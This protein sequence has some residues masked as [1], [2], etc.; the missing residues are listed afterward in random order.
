MNRKIALRSYLLLP[1]LAVAIFI[2]APVLAD[3]PP[4]AAPPAAPASPA[5]LL[6]TRAGLHEGYARL[7]FAAPPGSDVPNPA[8]ATLEGTQLRVQLAAP[9]GGSLAQVSRVL[10]S[11]I[12]GLSLSADRRV[13]TGTLKRPARLQVTQSAKGVAVIDLFDEAKPASEPP[14]P[15]PPEPA[16]PPQTASVP[17]PKPTPAVIDKTPLAP[18][19]KPAPVKPVESPAPPPVAAK[20]PAPPV[21]PE[22]LGAPVGQSA[23]KGLQIHYTELDDGVSI[24]FDWSQ[25]TSAAVFRRGGGVY[26]VFDRDQKIDFSD[27]KPA[28]WP[29][30]TAI[31][32]VATLSGIAIRFTSAGGYLPIV[33]RAGNSWIV[34]L[35]RRPPQLD[36]AL[37][38]AVKRDANGAAVELTPLDPASPISLTDPDIGDT[39]VAVPLPQLGQGV[40]QASAY[41]E[42]DL[43]A[44]AQGVAVRPLSDQLSIRTLPGRIRIETQGGL[45]LAADEDRVLPAE[46]PAASGVLLHLA[47][48]Q[49]K[50]TIPFTLRKQALYAG[51]VAAS[52]DDRNARRLDLAKFYF[53][54]AMAAETLG[55]LRNAEREVPNLTDDPGIKLMQ[56]ASEYLAGEDDAAA[57]DLGDRA[58][59]G[60]A[61]TALWRAALAAE[62]Q[63]WKTA[64]PLAKAGQDVVRDYP[65]ALG[66][67]LMLVLADAMLRTGNRKDAGAL[68]ETV[69]KRKSTR[70]QQDEADYLAGRVA[71][72]TG[73]PAK[74]T[75]YWTEAAHSPAIDLG[76]AQSAFAL[77][78]LNYESGAISRSDAIAA[79]DRLRYA[80][81]GDDFE[82]QVLRKLAD[83]YVADGDFRSAFDTLKRIPTGFPDTDAARDATQ[84]MQ[85]D[86]VD[87]FLS[88]DADKLSPLTALG[89]YQEFKEL[90]PPGDDGDRI[91]RKLA[92][93]LVAVDLLERAGNLLDDQVKNR[94]AGLDQARVA[95]QLALVRLLD[96]QPDLA[97]AA[98]DVK[99]IDGLPADLVRQRTELRARALV[100]LGKPDE[101]LTALTG[102]DGADADRLRAEIYE[103]QQ[104]WPLL[105]ATLR[106]GLKE[107]ESGGKLDPD[108][109]LTVLRLAN[110][111]VLGHDSKGLDALQWRYAAAMDQT[112]YRDAFRILAGTGMAE[113]GPGTIADRVAQIGDLQSF[114]TSYKQR[115]Q[116]DKLSA[117]N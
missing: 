100:D 89:L 17:A 4:P 7:V 114:M 102:D 3:D 13:V 27:F 84:Q 10:A 57:A 9:L 104:N 90:T 70:G 12:D 75:E 58:L 73:G 11:Y 69:L 36:G 54:N 55:V 60:R 117:I 107:P 99:V 52:D 108:S 49:G 83:L 101:A 62:Q 92:D 113:T 96:H 47:D 77:T 14:K 38:A 25:P 91:I 18:P 109:V 15:P 110:A 112:P 98:L 82:I 34:D 68:A 65:P 42:F 85:K 19:T 40:Q 24:R 59:D 28:N 87:M 97:L 41:P 66:N 72:E 30:V 81:R 16:P 8:A 1:L 46:A 67:R 2:A 105:A 80:W 50:A 111:L 86:F 51:L 116:Q 5:P 115:L 26:V 64:G 29:V 21:K 71:A 53:A 56:G 78:L 44:T 106:K 88:P 79:V 22:K 35:Q 61:D 39:L 31:Q 45:T 32:Q 93:R 63:D 76:H 6:E 103:K 94:L 37:Q 95:A 74:A 23:E 33:R 48:W 43:L 20:P